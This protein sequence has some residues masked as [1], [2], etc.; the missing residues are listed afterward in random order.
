VDVRRTVALGDDAVVGE[1]RVVEASN[2][3]LIY[4]RMKQ[5][6]K[7]KQKSKSFSVRKTNTHS[8]SSK[9][10]KHKK[11]TRFTRR[12]KKGGN[13]LTEKQY[14]KI[15]E[16]SEPIR[17]AREELNIL[18]ENKNNNDKKLLAI[19]NYINLLT[20]DKQLTKVEKSRLALK[21]RYALNAITK[22]NDNKQ[23]V[24]TNEP[25]NSIYSDKDY[26][27]KLQ[28][29]V[30][31]GHILDLARAADYAVKNNLIS[32][33]DKHQIE[34]ILNKNNYNTNSIAINSETYDKDYT[35]LLGLL[36]APPPPAPPPGPPPP[37]PPGPPPPLPPRPVVNIN[38][39]DEIA[40]LREEEAAAKVERKRE[41]EQE[42]HELKRKRQAAK[43]EEEINLE[44]QA[45]EL[46]RNLEEQAQEYSRI[47]ADNKQKNEE[48]LR[49]L[50]EQQRE[51]ENITNI[52]LMKEAQKLQDI[53]EAGKIKEAEI[54]R[55]NNLK[56]KQQTYYVNINPKETTNS[57]G[58]RYKS[59]RKH[60]KLSFRRTKK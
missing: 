57:I 45:Q 52:E 8:Q 27:D 56:P 32:D 15:F 19:Q 6:K 29:A 49:N 31:S 22:Q 35:E 59:H 12:I 44:E 16:K 46:K 3:I 30:N 24:P 5:T 2:L 58:G 37:L 36:S 13:Y 14:E 43:K 18:L 21:A 55:Q 38:E 60:K 54:E 42:Q 9:N 51:N 10:K 41:N 28:I 17:K 4:S 25:V 34:E 33:N 7:N 39:E 1:A 23:P 53:K 47:L 50:K 20:I 40:Q 48:N 11:N 26:S